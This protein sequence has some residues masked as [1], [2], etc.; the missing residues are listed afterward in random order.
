[1]KKLNAKITEVIIVGNSELII[2]GFPN[3]SEDKTHSC[4]EAGCGSMEHV[5]YRYGKPMVETTTN[6]WNINIVEIHSEKPIVINGIT[7][8]EVDVTTNC[9]GCVERKIRQFTFTDWEIAKQ[10]GYWVG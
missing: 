7:Y 4:D 10:K 3:N 5:V 8:I 9:W 6:T 1:M 2:M